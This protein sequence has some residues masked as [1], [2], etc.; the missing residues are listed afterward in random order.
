MTYLSSRLWQLKE[1]NPKTIRQ[2]KRDGTYFKLRL[3]KMVRDITIEAKGHTCVECKHLSYDH[4]KRHISVYTEQA[5][6]CSPHSA[7]C[8]AFF[9]EDC[10]LKGLN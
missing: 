7:V 9:Q 4:C 3:A 8:F 5:I 1:T 10:A 6:D 2:L